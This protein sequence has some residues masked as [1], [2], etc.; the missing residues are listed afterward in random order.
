[1]ANESGGSNMFDMP[2]EMRAFAEKGLEQA[3]SAFDAFV[4]AA[5]QAATVAQTQAMTAQNGAR[6]LGQL[7]MR[8]AER[9]IASSFDFA[10]KLMHAKD[11]GEV[12]ALHSEYVSSQMAALTE[13][14]RELGRQASKMGGNASSH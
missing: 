3:K 12:A 2:V 10:Q 8:Y 11:A 6:E 5:Q 14:A 7:A 4:N 1:M 9:N 13:Q